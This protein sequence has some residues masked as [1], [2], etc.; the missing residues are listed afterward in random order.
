M[1]NPKKN[2]WK[3]LLCRSSTPPSSTP[4]LG[5]R[6]RSA[7]N[8]SAMSETSDGAS[9]R[10]VVEQVISSKL[11]E[12][13][14]KMDKKFSDFEKSLEFSMEQMEELRVASTVKDVQKKLVLIEKRQEKEENES[15]EWKSKIR[16]LETLVQELNQ[17]SENCK[18][19]LSGFPTNLN[20]EVNNIA[21]ELLSKVDGSHIGQV[22]AERVSKVYGQQTNRTSIVMKFESVEK[23]NVILNK[24]K[25]EKIHLKAGDLLKTG[26]PTP[27]YVNEFLTSY[28]RRLFYEA[29]KLK[30]DKK[31]AYLWVEDGKILLKK[32][33]DS[34]VV[35][36]TSMEDLGKI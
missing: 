26:D 36:L 1:S 33:Q 15:K 17:K 8:T 32:T 35:R 16:G 7:S 30:M 23:R 5:T 14:K 22:T 27:V 34:R 25:Q 18:L 19:E 24:I 4:P 3:C 21:R 9:W 28:Y 11:D 20:V 6:S 10:N 12:Y 2:S 13:M 31:Y 29:K